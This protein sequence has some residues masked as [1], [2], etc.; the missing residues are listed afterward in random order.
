M[1]DGKGQ[2]Q[3]VGAGKVDGVPAEVCGGT[4]MV[5]QGD[6]ERPQR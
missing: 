5:D 1:E 3:E 6:N 4:A 2:V